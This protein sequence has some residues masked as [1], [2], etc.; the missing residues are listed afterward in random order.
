MGSV[1]LINRLGGVH[2]NVSHYNNSN[3]AF[4]ALEM[5]EVGHPVDAVRVQLDSGESLPEMTTEEFQSWF[6]KGYEEPHV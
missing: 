1:A 2:I 3:D 6:M 4:L 5:G